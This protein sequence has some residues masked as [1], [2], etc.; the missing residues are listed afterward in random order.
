MHDL[1]P[2]NRDSL[3]FVGMRSSSCQ[4][5]ILSSSVVIRSIVGFFTD[6]FIAAPSNEFSIRR[7]LMADRSEAY[8]QNPG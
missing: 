2:F 5:R 3:L 6:R 1:L 4:F 7:G 8:S